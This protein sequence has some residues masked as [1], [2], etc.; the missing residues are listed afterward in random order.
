[1]D[2]Y[3]VTSMDLAPSN[4]SIIFKLS[5]DRLGEYADV[6][7]YIPGKYHINTMKFV[8]KNGSVANINGDCAGSHIAQDLRDGAVA[9]VVI[10]IA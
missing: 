1:M 2:K 8:Y 9:E 6:M 4:L 10:E 3:S 5:G 7:D